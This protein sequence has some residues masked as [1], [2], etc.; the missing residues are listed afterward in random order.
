MSSDYFVDGLFHR[1]MTT[2]RMFGVIVWVSI[3]DLYKF[4]GLNVR[5]R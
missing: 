2:A 1:Q 4:F 5:T 3:V